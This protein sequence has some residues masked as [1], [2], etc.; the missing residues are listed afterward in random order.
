MKTNY[1]TLSIWFLATFFIASFAACE[2]EDT[3]NDVNNVATLSN[4]SANWTL[5][6]GYSDIYSLHE[7]S[8]K[9][10]DDECEDAFDG[11][12]NPL[13]QE[14]DHKRALSKS[15]TYLQAL[16]TYNQLLTTTEENVIDTTINS[17]VDTNEFE[18]AYSKQ[19]VKINFR[20]D[21]TLKKNGMYRVYIIYNYYEPDA[22]LY[23]DQDTIMQHGKTYSGTFEYLSKWLLLENSIGLESKLLL[24]G[25][26]L[27]IVSIIPVY[28]LSN[29]SDIE[30]DYNFVSDIDFLIHDQVFEFE[31][32]S[33]MKMTLMAINGDNSFDQIRDAE[34][35]AYRANG[36][37]IDC[38][39]VYTETQVTTENLYFEFI[40]DGIDV[41]D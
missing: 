9:W 23:S 39:G 31:Q 33:S 21:L 18:D 37:T 40:S 22:P 5:E 20:Y 34:F 36:T 7:S 8:Y 26:P 24:T 13:P 15:I 16:V 19:D 3:K 17:S 25:F 27:P 2:K 38:E 4:L 41:E 6:S 12:S 29:P 28:D 35:E 10:L 30:L 11:N 1:F 32:I 14:Y